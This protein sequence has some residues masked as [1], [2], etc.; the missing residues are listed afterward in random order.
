VQAAEQ[1]VALRVPRQERAAQPEP[2]R[3]R[4]R[5]EKLGRAALLGH[6]DLVREVPRILRRSGMKLW[7]SKGFHPKPAMT[8]GPA[9]SLGVPSFEEW[10]DI[11]TAAAIDVDTI[12]TA[13]NAV[14]PDGL[15][16][17]SATQLEPG[18]K[19][20]T[21]E[22]IQTTML[23]GL[24][25]DTVALAGGRTWLSDRIHHALSAEA[26][27]VSRSSKGRE[28]TVDIRPFLLNVRVDDAQADVFARAGL[29][30]AWVPVLVDL[31]LGPDGT[32]R[33]DEVVSMLMDGA[34]TRYRA[35]RLSF[36]K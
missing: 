31:A 11:K 32:A 17:A 18:A 30:G 33:M 22:L 25:S 28:R 23:L 15:R 34:E 7:Y 26:L 21:N 36:R 14:C 19:A 5:Y 1:V 35:A 2:F 29:P 9:L 16:F 6:L 10:V 12:V 4:F 20:I 3:Y 24:A 27:P 8:F 13:I